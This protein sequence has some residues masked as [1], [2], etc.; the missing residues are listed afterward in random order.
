MGIPL[1]P[2][3]EVDTVAYMTE[4]PDNLETAAVLL[5]T[6]IF[7]RNLKITI[8]M[9]MSRTRT[10]S[11]WCCLA[12]ALMGTAFGITVVYALLFSGLCCRKIF[13]LSGFI[14]TM[15]IMCNSI[16]LL[17]KA[18]LVLC[19]KRWIAI[20]GTIF[21]LPQLG[22]L[23]IVVVC[24]PVTIEPNLG[25]V[26]YYPTYLPLYWFLAS[27]PISLFFSA[28]FSHIAYRQYSMFGS[29]A[30]KRLARDGI[31][32]MCLAVICNVVCGIIIV[33]Q[34]GGNYAIMFYVADW[35]LTSTILLNHCQNMRKA[36]KLPNRPKTRHL[37]KLSQIPTSKSL[38]IDT[39]LA[40]PASK[41]SSVAPLTCNDYEEN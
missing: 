8:G 25:C 26:L 34:I 36:S 7:I 21:T 23:V 29:D 2:L 22:F 12:P 30:W 17:Q 5:S 20:F 24:C 14:N 15:A 38:I 6:F 41:Y 39:P 13:W 19:R 11:S 3:G 35:L 32:T 16:V 28:I 33:F 10:L 37:I 31:Q 1:H 4:F 27:M 40:S 18:Y 9:V